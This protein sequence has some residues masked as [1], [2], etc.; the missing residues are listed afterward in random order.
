MKGTTDRAKDDPN[1][2]EDPR[3]E[4]EEAKEAPAAKVPGGQAASASDKEN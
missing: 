4:E 3:E 1:T 2:P